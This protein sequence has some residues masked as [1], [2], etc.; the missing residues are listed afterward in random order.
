MHQRKDSETERH[1]L[2]KRIDKESSRKS[3][4]NSHR[5]KKNQNN[6]QLYISAFDGS[7]KTLPKYSDSYQSVKNLAPVADC[8]K[9]QG[10]RADQNTLQW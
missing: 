8:L 3:S 5:E 2:L 1:H 9:G 10:G 6:S 7:H 4:L